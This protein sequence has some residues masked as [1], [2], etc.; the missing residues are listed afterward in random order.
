[1]TLASPVFPIPFEAIY[2]SIDESG[3]H[4]SDNDGN[5][6]NDPA[7]DDYIDDTELEYREGNVG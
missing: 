7:D 4:N 2:I 1:M 5:D 3:G 6:G